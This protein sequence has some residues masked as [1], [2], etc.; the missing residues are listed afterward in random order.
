MGSRI[1]SIFEL[2]TRF[3]VLSRTPRAIQIQQGGAHRV[4]SPGCSSNNQFTPKNKWVST[5]S[6]YYPPESSAV[7]RTNVH[8]LDNNVKIIN[9]DNYVLNLANNVQ[10][11]G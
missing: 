10:E 8:N 5:L 4:L 9:C 7:T 6:H 3:C 1:D 2:Q 11:P